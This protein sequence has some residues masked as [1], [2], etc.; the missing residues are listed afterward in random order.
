MAP[1]S[2]T[3]YHNP[4]C[5]TSRNVLALLRAA[6]YEPQ[7]IEYLKAP[8]DPATLTHLLSRMGLPA[9]DLLRLRGTPNAQSGA[10]FASMD[11]E[12]IISAMVTQPILINR[13]IVVAPAGVHLCRPSDLVI[14]LLPERPVR[15]LRKEDGSPVLVDVPVRGDDEGLRAT[16]VQAGLPIADL[17][18]AGRRMFAYDDLA[19]NRLGY[20]GL[21]IHGREALL[22][23]IV[24]APAA[25]DRGVGTSVLA[26]LLR[27]AFDVGARR[28]WLLTT[29]A[30]AYFERKGFESVERETAPAAILSSREAME[31]CPSS[32][33]IFTRPIEP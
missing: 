8:P 24:V 29:T 10:H 22:R 2:I 17:A 31:L 21:E 12:A 20:G 19:G 13:P 9:R 26:L 16:L 28:A 25:R 5:G 15:E 30:A 27:R 1:G 32:A 11:D 33:M 3:I 4:A 18:Q 7:V 14:E 23:S 6:G